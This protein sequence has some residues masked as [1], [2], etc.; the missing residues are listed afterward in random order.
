MTPNQ[1]LGELD[2]FRHRSP[3]PMTSANVMSNVAGT[4]LGGWSGLAQEVIGLLILYLTSCPHVVE[5]FS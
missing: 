5:F 2:R 4:G 1:I 3:S